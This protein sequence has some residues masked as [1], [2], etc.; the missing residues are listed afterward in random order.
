TASSQ[1]VAPGET[2]TLSIKLNLLPDAHANSNSPTDPNLVATVFT[3]NKTEGIEWGNTKYPQPTTVIVTYSVEPLSV[4][5]DGAIITVPVSVAPAIKS[6][7]V[8][9]GGNL[10]IQVCDRLQC[11]PP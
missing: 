6:N 8:T 10:R 3:P 4:F 9:V 5:E 2:I 7:Q 1:T 11:Y